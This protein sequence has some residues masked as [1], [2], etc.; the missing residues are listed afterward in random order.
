MLAAVVLGFLAVGLAQLQKGNR[1]AVL[2]IRARDG[3]QAVATEVIDS[4]KRVGLS[5]V[6]ITAADSPLDF[7]KSR[8]FEGAVGKTTVDYNVRVGIREGKASADQTGLTRE[9]PDV[10]NLEYDYAKNLDV[11]VEWKFKNS[12]QSI[13]MSAVIK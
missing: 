1:E 5:S 12:E 8:T 11:I 4:L 2:R 13:S 6:K 9:D 3:A 10:S 7:K